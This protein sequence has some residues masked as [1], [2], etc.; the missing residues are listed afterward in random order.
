LV[1]VLLGTELVPK[2]AGVYPVARRYVPATP[3]Y[4]TLLMRT[5]VIFDTISSP[6]ELNAGIIDQTQFPVLVTVL[7]L[8]A[9]LPTIVA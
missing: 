6:Y 9:I 3:R 5:G 1:P 8:T 4:T 7:V 2:M